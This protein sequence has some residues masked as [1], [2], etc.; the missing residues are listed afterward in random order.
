MSNYCTRR[1]GAHRVRHGGLIEKTRFTV[2]WRGHEW[3]VDAFAGENVGLVIAE[4][5]LRHEAETFD[6]PPWLG[7]EITG[8]AQYYN[9]SLSRRP[10]S[11]WAISHSAAAAG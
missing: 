7:I 6:R 11:H 10:F 9:G 4:I 3:K 2:P 1:R 5:V 8:Q